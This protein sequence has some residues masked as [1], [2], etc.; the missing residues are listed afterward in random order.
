MIEKMIRTSKIRRAAYD[1]KARELYIETPD[2][3]AFVYENVGESIAERFFS[4]SSPGS[5]FEDVIVE[6]YTKKPLAKFPLED[7]KSLNA[8]KALEALFK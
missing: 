7:Q 1:K 8:K 2:R 5:Y 6:G 3:R 4:S